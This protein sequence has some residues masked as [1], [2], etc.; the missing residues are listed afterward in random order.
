MLTI[1]VEHKKNNNT[2]GEKAMTW[3]D[4]V[5]ASSGA[6]NSLKVFN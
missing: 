6:K 3:Y 1:T 4:I 2:K 5:Q